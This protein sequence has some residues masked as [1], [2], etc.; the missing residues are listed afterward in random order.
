MFDCANLPMGV[1]VVVRLH[2]PKRFLEFDHALFSLVNQSFRPVHAIVV[3]QSFGAT[4]ETEMRAAMDAFDWQ[5]RGHCAP[6]MID[7]A[8]PTGKDIRAQLLN[9]GVGRARHRF[10]AFLDFDDYLYEDAYDYLVREAVSTRAAIAFG[11]ILCRSVRVF[12]RFV[13]SAKVQANPF[14]GKDAADLI[15][16]NFC[17]IHSFVIDR[18]RVAPDDLTFNPDLERLEDYDLLLR[19]CA[20]YTSRF[21]S[22]AKRIGVYNWH[23]DGRG[24]TQFF[25][26]DP[27]KTAA[28]KR[29]SDQ[30]RRHIRRLKWTLRSQR[31]S[32]PTSMD[33]VKCSNRG[34]TETSDKVPPL[35]FPLGHF[36]SPVAD[37]DDVR[38][39]EGRLWSRADEMHGI[40]LNVTAQLALLP[41][42]RPHTV[43]I[44]YP[45]HDPGD[46][47]TY[48]YSNDQY[49]VLDAEFLHAALCLFRPKAM[50][51]VGA[52]FSSLITAEVNRRLLNNRL[53]FTCIE[54]Y[55]R[56]FL[57]DGVEGITRLVQARVEDVD[58]SLF[59]R[60]E[61]GD[62]L[63]IDSSHVSKVGSDVNH[64]FFNVLPRLRSG[65]LVHIHDIF[66]PDEYPKHWVIDEGRNW[67]E[68]YLLRA[69]LE[70]NPC[71]EVIWAAH[72][73]GTR[74]PEA[75][76]MTFPRYPELG[77]G[78]SFW[79]RRT[80]D[81][82]SAA[83]LF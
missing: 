17:P 43:S 14:P 73:M 76:R 23:L 62:I 15:V 8:A 19:L 16:D 41:Q 72:Y 12:D 71:F 10:L 67:N 64:F 50:I 22:R 82:R 60:L 56:Q 55:P 35:L 52:G 42:L 78:G 70:F 7:V 25:G 66:L 77:G 54:P 59:D 51:E 2:D 13:Y 3:T 18:E 34:A 81:L 47:S 45:I 5:E 32:R 30:A 11:G 49:P 39:R 27:A 57:V 28:D 38:A 44:N 40:D 36:Y 69:F 1:D 20:K 31:Q 46:G 75:V 9:A 26:G 80:D 4:M 68:Q 83:P 37:P 58:L 24:T 6:T 61:A 74:H 63:F 48:F 65:V 21:E 79:I 33:D 53:D 29:A